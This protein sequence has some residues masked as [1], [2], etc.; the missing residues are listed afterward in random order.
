MDHGTKENSREH[1]ASNEKIDVR[2]LQPVITEDRSYW[3][4]DRC[5]ERRYVAPTKQHWRRADYGGGARPQPL[6]S[7]QENARGQRR[8]NAVVLDYNEYKLAFSKKRLYAPYTLANTEQNL[9]SAV[10]TYF[11]DWVNKNEKHLS[12]CNLALIPIPE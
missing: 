5:H 10:M 9:A 1:P 6:A 11:E 8:Q 7:H 3:L 2:L 4:R 12:L